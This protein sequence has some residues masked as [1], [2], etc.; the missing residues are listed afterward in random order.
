MVFNTTDGGDDSTTVNPVADAPVV[1]TPASE[2][3]TPEVV[4]PTPEV[5]PEA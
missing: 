2:E 5:T 1:T 4:T 3:T